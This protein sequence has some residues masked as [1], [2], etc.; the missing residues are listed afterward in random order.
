MYFRRVSWLLSAVLALQCC[1]ASNEEEAA[2]P[3]VLASLG[4][5]LTAPDGT[6]T[7][8][9]CELV[10]GSDASASAVLFV[11][12]NKLGSNA[13]QLVDLARA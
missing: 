10:L 13:P 6:Q 3:P 9:A 5:T 12:E 4:M 7:A 8:V 2:R 11:A 1:V